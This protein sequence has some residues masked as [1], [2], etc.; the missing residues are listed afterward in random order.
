MPLDMTPAVIAE[1][2]PDPSD[3]ILEVADTWMA[4][5]EIC[6]IVR[7]RTGVGDHSLRRRLMA[8]KDRGRILCV[9][10]LGVP[11]YKRRDA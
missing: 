1:G 3:I 4:S 9:I 5:T 8:L 10:I 6:E 11:H 2:T 7:V